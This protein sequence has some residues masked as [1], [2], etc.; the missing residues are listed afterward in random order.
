MFDAIE[1]LMRNWCAIYSSKLPREQNAAGIQ[2]L[3]L[4]GRMLGS[5]IDLVDMG[6]EKPTPL[7]IAVCKRLAKDLDR[8]HGILNAIDLENKAMRKHQ[9][10]LETARSKVL[11]LLFHLQNENNR[12]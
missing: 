6:R 12:D 10:N 11:Q 4:Y 1:F 3:S 8:V 2:A 5:A 9:V 7:K